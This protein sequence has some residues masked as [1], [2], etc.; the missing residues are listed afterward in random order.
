M[1]SVLISGAMFLFLAAMMVREGLSD[2]DGI[3]YV[4][5]NGDGTGKQCT[6]LFHSLCSR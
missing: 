6:N 5:E 1:V 3:R 2:D 4:R